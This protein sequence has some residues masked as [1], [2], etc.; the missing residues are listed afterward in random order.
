MAQAQRPLSPHLEIY[1]WYFAMALS[2]L[3]RITGVALTFGLA[4]LTIWLFSVAMGPEAYGWVQWFVDSWIGVL[5]LFGF[6]FALFFHFA[7]GVRHLV[8]DAGY[9]FDLDNARLSGFATLIFAGG[10]TVILWFI[11]L[12]F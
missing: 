4:L 11:V 9:G 7:N 10:M 6:T 3:H 12:I 8:W 5:V 2:T 1:R